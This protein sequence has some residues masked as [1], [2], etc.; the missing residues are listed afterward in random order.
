MLTSLM[1]FCRLWCVCVRGSLL[2]PVDS[3]SQWLCQHHSGCPALL[4]CGH[5]LAD[6]AVQGVQ[7]IVCHRWGGGGSAS[8]AVC[9][10]AGCV[11]AGGHVA[12]S[13][14]NALV[15]PCGPSGSSTDITPLAGRVKNISSLGT[16][17]GVCCRPL[18]SDIAPEGWRELACCVLLKSNLEQVQTTMTVLLRSRFWR[19]VICK[20][21]SLLYTQVWCI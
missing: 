11:C 15:V 13:A 18:S 10:G 16:L 17:T 19:T 20:Q 4:G 9:V 6:S 7:D 5:L 12:G 3:F 1:C 21:G 8:E 14:H 2:R